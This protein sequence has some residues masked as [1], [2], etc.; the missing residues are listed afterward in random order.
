MN[1]Q[2]QP[3]TWE[4]VRRELAMPFPV[5]QVQWKPAIV[6]GNRALALAYIDAR[7][8]MNRLDAVVGPGGWQDTYTVLD[9]GL[10]ICRLSLTIGS[11]WVA[12]EDIGEPGEQTGKGKAA[13]SDAFKRVA[14]KWGIGRYLYFL[15]KLW[16]DYDPNTKRLLV[17]KITLPPWAMPPEEQKARAAA[18]MGS[19]GKPQPA[20]TPNPPNGHLPAATVGRIQSLIAEAGAKQGVILQEYKAQGIGQLTDKQAEEIIRRLELEIRE[21][22]GRGHDP[23]GDDPNYPY[24]PDYID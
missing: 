17:E 6:K 20:A 5:K 23:D 4:E 24:P 18:V 2:S 21:Q 15:P 3:K 8:V 22:E 11:E 9:D 12:K 13:F 7:Q 14:V 10:I 19:A 1:Q 16:A